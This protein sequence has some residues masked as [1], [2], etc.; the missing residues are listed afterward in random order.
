MTLINHHEIF[1]EDNIP[2]RKN[3]RTQRLL[4]ENTNTK[5]TYT[6][7]KEGEN[8]IKNGRNPNKIDS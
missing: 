6:I 7:P 4:K 5:G 2:T 1:I 8:S 3:I